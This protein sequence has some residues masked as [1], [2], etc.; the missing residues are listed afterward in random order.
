MHRYITK[1]GVN[2]RETVPLYLFR[3]SWCTLVG[4]RRL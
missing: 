3:G 4:S 1:T 2:S